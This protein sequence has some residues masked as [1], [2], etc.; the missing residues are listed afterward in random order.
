VRWRGRLVRSTIWKSPL[1]GR[2]RVTRF[3]LDGDRQADPAVHGGHEKAIYVYPSEHYAYWRGMLG[4]LPWGSFGENFTTAG[5]LEEDV[6]IGDQLSIGSAL[7]EVT[8]PRTPCMK[9]ALRFQ[10]PAIVRQFR[11]SRRSGGEPH[12]GYAPRSLSTTRHRRR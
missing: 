10:R 7:L 5:L 4:E 3:N 2:V 8:Q 9:L 1:A 6:R 12:R 11:E